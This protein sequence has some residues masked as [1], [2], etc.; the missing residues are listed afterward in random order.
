M[1]KEKIEEQENENAKKAEEQLIA[2]SP[3]YGYLKVP[4]EVRS[5]IKDR[6]RMKVKEYPNPLVFYNYTEDKNE[7]ELVYKFQ[8]EKRKE[9]NEENIVK[10]NDE[11]E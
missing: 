6:Y 11:D 10:E 2:T 4:S 1:N 8:F 3:G 9:E 5:L 7:L